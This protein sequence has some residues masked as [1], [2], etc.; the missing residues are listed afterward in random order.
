MASAMLI[1][2]GDDPAAIPLIDG[3]YLDDV[4]YPCGGFNDGRMCDDP[5]VIETVADANDGDSVNRIWRI[6]GCID[7][8]Q[9]QSFITGLAPGGRFISAGELTAAGWG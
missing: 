5:G 3:G 2:A 9:P 1:L 6:L 8:G 4:A 7:C